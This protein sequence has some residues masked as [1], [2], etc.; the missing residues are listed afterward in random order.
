M[1]LRDRFDIVCSRDV[2]CKAYAQ[3][4]GHDNMTS[5]FTVGKAE[6]TGHNEK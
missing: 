3:Q 5:I 6:P 1:D 2:W 4:K